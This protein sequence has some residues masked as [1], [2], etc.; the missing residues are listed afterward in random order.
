[1]A[2]HYWCDAVYYIEIKLEFILIVATIVSI[3][4]HYVVTYWKTDRV[5]IYYFVIYIIQGILVHY[6]TVN[7]FAISSYFG[8]H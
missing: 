6:D 5:T 8:S 3:N 1:M 2:L 7:N 4:S